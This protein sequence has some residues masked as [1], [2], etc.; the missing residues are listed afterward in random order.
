MTSHRLTLGIAV[1][2]LLAGTT[3]VQAATPTAAEMAYKNYHEGVYAAVECRGAVFSPADYQI[4]ET[5]ILTQ[6]GGAIHAGR[7]LDLIEAAKT[8]IGKAMSHAGCGATEVKEAL[9]RFDTIRGYQVGEVPK[10]Q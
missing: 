10:K 4:L 9:V 2:G 3:A 5:R 1:A 8:D 7:Q 6:S